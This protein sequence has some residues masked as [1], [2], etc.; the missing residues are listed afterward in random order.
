V[1]GSLRKP[2]TPGG[3]WS[4]RL[5][6]GIGPD[7]RRQQKQVSG[8]PTR[9]SAQAA[10]NEALAEHQYGAYVAPSKRT[11]AEFVETWLEA[12]RPEVAESAWVNYRTLLRAYV[13]PRVGQV[14]LVDLT[15]QRLQ[16]LYADLLTHGRRDGTSLSARTVAQTHK[17]LHR[18]L[19]DAVRWRE[20]PRNP[21][22]HARAPRFEAKEMTAWS[23]DDCRRFLDATAGDRLAALW[24]L[25]L[26]SGMR[27]GELAGLRW[28]D[29]DLDDGAVAVTQQRT[30]ADYRVVVAEPKARSRRVITL[31]ASVVESLRAHRRRQLDERLAAGPGWVDSGYVFVD[32][33]GCPYHPTRLRILFERACHAAGVPPIRLHD[34]RHIMATTALRA[35]IHPKIVQERLG[36]SSIA[37]TLDTYSHVTPT[38]QR[39]AAEKLGR[40]FSE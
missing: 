36:H 33:L 29:V 6:L 35:G 5:D 3:T 22:D 7:G 32:E 40:M 17:T 11:L 15:P 20:I 37:L 25:A 1:R 13:V 38:L 23:M 8:F 27:R 34:L 21:S 12:V 14:R 2:R 16:A 19:E 10:L 30:T 31:D 26:N 18:A 39:A 28:P 24:L 9:R 4:Y